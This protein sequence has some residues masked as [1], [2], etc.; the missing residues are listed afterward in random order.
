MSKNMI[1]ANVR[2]TYELLTLFSITLVNGTVWLGQ[3]NR[4]L[5]YRERN[6]YSEE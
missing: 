4:K 6:I 2:C 5:S 1:T 3:M